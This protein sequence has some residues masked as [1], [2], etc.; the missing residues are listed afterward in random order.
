MSDEEHRE[1]GR[2]WEKSLDRLMETTPP[3]SLIA[4]AKVYYLTIPNKLLEARDEQ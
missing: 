4:F 2:W 1:L 3:S